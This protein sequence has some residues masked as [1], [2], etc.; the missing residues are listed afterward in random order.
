MKTL[1]FLL[2][3]F[4]VVFAATCP[5]GEMRNLTDVQG[6]QLV[7][8]ILEVNGSDVKIRRNDGRIFVMKLETLSEADR[9]YVGNLQD[10]LMLSA[11]KQMRI[12]VARFKGPSRTMSGPREEGVSYQTICDGGFSV[13][14]KNMS[15]VNLRGLRADYRVYMSRAGFREK[16]ASQKNIGGTQAVDVL[17]RGDTH[18]FKTRTMPLMTQSLQAN[19]YYR[20]E[21]GI[22]RSLVDDLLGVWVRVYVGKELVAEYVS[23]EILRKIG[24]AGR[25][26]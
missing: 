22:M 14:L 4:G 9:D 11:A 3:I 13:S 21:A 19:W 25:E 26:M 8:E 23:S 5:A 15:S 20:T 17:A 18:T 6:R 12:E 10:S 2:L 1:K 24:W 7:A 16:K